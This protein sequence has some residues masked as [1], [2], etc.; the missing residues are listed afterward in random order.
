MFIKFQLYLK[1]ATG[2]WSIPL[3]WFVTEKEEHNN[4]FNNKIDSELE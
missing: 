3:D 2:S 4:T 1:K